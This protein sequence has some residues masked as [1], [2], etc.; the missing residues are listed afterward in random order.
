MRAFLSSSRTASARRSVATR[1]PL[2][3]AAR[4]D[5]ARRWPARRQPAADRVARAAPSRRCPPA[6][7]AHRLR[8]RCAPHPCASAPRASCGAPSRRRVPSGNMTT[9]WPSRASSIAVAIASSSCSPRRTRKPPPAVMTRLSGNQNSSDFAMKRKKRR[10]KSGIASGQG[11][12]F[13]Q[14][15]AASTN[16]PVAGRCSTPVAR[17][18]KTTLTTGQLTAPTRR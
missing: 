11:S 6:R 18:R 15:F 4:R 13:D 12:K 14:W 5:R 7:A 8:A 16:P 2:R 17:C 1:P 3:S 9:A 10:G